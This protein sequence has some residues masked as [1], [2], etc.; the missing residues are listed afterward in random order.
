MRPN[1]YDDLLVKIKCS[2]D[3]RKRMEEQLSKAPSEASEYEDIVSGTDVIK[4]RKWGS[5]AAMAAA[6]VLV[7]GAVGGGTYYY[8]SRGDSKIVETASIEDIYSVVKSNVSGNNY[9]IQVLLK[10][11]IQIVMENVVTGKD[12]FFGYMDNAPSCDA[13]DRYSV[14]ETENYITITF[15]NISDDY[16]SDDVQ[17]YSFNVYESGDCIWKEEGFGYSK[18]YCYR[19]AEGRKVYD[20][21]F[22]M[23]KPDD[24]TMNKIAGTINDNVRFHLEKYLVN[25]EKPVYRYVGDNKVKYRLVDRKGLIDELSSEK[26]QVATDIYGNDTY[27]AGITISSSGYIGIN[28]ADWHF[29]YKL[30]D[31]SDDRFRTILEEHLIYD[32]FG[33]DATDDDINTINN[34]LNDLRDKV[35][36][37]RTDGGELTPGTDCS[38]EDLDGLKKELAALEWVTCEYNVEPLYRDFYA[39]GTIISRNGYIKP[40]VGGVSQYAYKLKNEDDLEKFREICD[41]H[42]SADGFSELGTM[43]QKSADSYNTLSGT[44]SACYQPGSTDYHISGDISYDK[45]SELFYLSGSG[46]ELGCLDPSDDIRVEVAMKGDKAVICENSGG[47]EDK[48]SSPHRERIYYYQLYSEV[49]DLLYRLKSTDQKCRA[50]KAVL[51]NGNTQYKVYIGESSSFCYTSEFDSAGHLI[52]FSTGYGDAEGYFFRLDSCEFD[53]DSFDSSYLTDKYDSVKEK[54]EHELFSH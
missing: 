40:A 2:N 19:F 36:E 6:C 31:N 41:R 37:Y 5:F 4:P 8:K 16:S 21:I 20:D 30:A 3:F 29:C 54:I 49:I 23:Y 27:D 35:L 50:E 26:W 24:D 39:S 7:C 17:S 51:E 47:L 45:N 32:D 48:S 22:R 44:F 14:C 42:F 18:E 11:D 38:I 53:S 28:I 9:E 43:L 52:A 13:I 34:A 10:S 25:E 46:Y 1:E 33:S 12:L 15:H